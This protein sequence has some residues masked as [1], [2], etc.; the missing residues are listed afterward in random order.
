MAPPTTGIRRCRFTGCTKRAQTRRLCKAHGGGVRCRVPSCNKLVQTRGLCVK[1]GGG[2]RCSYKGCAKL[3]QY[4]GFCLSHGGGR[5]CSVLNCH[6]FV[7]MR[8]YCKR[9]GREFVPPSRD[10]SATRNRNPSDRQTIVSKLSL[11]FL[12]NPLDQVSALSVRSSPNY[13]DC[14]YSPR[15]P[16]LT[17][18]STAIG[19]IYPA[20]S[21]NN[22]VVY[23]Q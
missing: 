15:S 13:D 11:N 3:G 2:R 16:T 14:H 5:R 8:G 10:P 20:L 7:Q 22:I 12:L 21:H 18:F 23:P 1:H 6:K 17:T 9:H 4:T 19:T